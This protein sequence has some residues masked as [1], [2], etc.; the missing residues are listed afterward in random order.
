MHKRRGFTPIELIVVIA[1]I[2]VLA[3][4]L[5][6]ALLG[7]IDKSKKRSTT[8]AARTIYTAVMTALIDDDAAKAFYARTGGN[9]ATFEAANDGV[10]VSGSQCGNKTIADRAGYY[11]FAVVACCDGAANTRNPVLQYMERRQRRRAV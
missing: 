10:I 5:V 3:A 8:S 7:Y 6:P 11:H 4:I 2:G 1:I 9:F